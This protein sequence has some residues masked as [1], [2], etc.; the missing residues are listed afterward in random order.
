[1]IWFLLGLIGVFFVF[2]GVLFGDSP[3][4]SGLEW[5]MMSFEALVMSLIPMGAAAGLA[6]LIG[7]QFDTKPVLV[8]TDTLTTIRDKDGLTGSFFLGTG[9]I[10]GDQYYFYYRRLAD[11]GVSPGKV[12]AGSGVRVYEEERADATLQTYEWKLIS[13]WAWLVAL[14]VNSGGY[15]FDFHVPSGTVKQGFSM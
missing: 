9:S 6:A 15:S 12:Y 11:G 8:Q 1:M 5:I 14:P 7:T 3:P 13:D 4:E 2:K 10:K